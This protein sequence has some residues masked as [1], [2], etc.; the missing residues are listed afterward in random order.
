MGFLAPISFWFLSAIAVLLLFYFFKKQYEDQPVSWIYLWERTMKEWETDRWWKKLQ[1]NILLLLQVLFLLFLIFSL[2]RPFME[3]TEIRGDH[4]VVIIDSSATM[5]TQVNDQ[6]RFDQVKTEIMQLINQLGKDHRVS[7]IDAQTTPVLLF[8][9]E[10]NLQDAKSEVSSLNLSYQQENMRESINLAQ[11]L[12]GNDS[13]EIHIFSDQLKEN[14]LETPINNHL[15]VHNID[16]ELENISLQSFGV[17]QIGESVSAIVTIENQS[18]IDREVRV[19]VS[20]ANGILEEVSALIPIGEQRTLTIERMEISDYYEAKIGEDAYSLDNHVYAFLPSK[21]ETTLYLVGDVHPFMERALQSTGVETITLSKE[22]SATYTYPDEQEAIYVVAGVMESE[23]PKGAKLV[24]SPKEGGSFEIREK[25]ELA[26][27]LQ[28]LEDDPIMQYTNLDHMYL[29]K[30]YQ[31]GNWNGLEPIVKS[32]DQTILAKGNYQQAPIVMFP[33]DLQDSDWPLHPGFPILLANSLEFLTENKEL[34]YFD[35]MERTEIQLFPSTTEAI[36][37]TVDGDN[38]S[39]IDQGDSMLT[40]PSVPGLYQLHEKSANGSVFRAF[41]VQVPHQER[42]IEES[43]SFSIS[44]EGEQTSSI[45]FSKF[46][47]WRILATIALLILFIEWEVYRRG[48]ST[49]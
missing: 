2:T 10:T 4:L 33:L 37:E 42:V 21:Q 22:D 36:I 20:G 1:K 32:D 19:T 3:G 6:T 40:A 14:N 5:S 7:V 41:V 27:Q 39:E 25:V 44:G 45:A 35:P 26:Y 15:V 18:N 47:L 43:N 38:I 46:E 8:A 16:G 30:A 13:G 11:A 49:R 12:L 29:S 48:I 23:W 17:K 31:V 34:G 28:I 9:N 24:L